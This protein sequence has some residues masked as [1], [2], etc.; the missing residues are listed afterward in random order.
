MASAEAAIAAVGAFDPQFLGY[1][2]KEPGMIG[3]GPHVIV[4]PVDDDWEL[5]FVTGSGD[6]PAGCIDHAFAK[7]T[8]TRG[9]MVTLLCRWTTQSGVGVTSGKEC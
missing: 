6:C 8:V 1:G 3:E 7:F 4:V 9:G 5:T 2:Q